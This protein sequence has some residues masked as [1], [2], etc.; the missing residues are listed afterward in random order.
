[1][2]G[3]MKHSNVTSTIIVII[4]VKKRETFRKEAVKGG[5][6]VLIAMTGAVI[7][8]NVYLYYV[9]ILGGAKMLGEFVTVS[10]CVC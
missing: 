4:N 1:M 5:F 2:H 7:A 6:I 3:A 10:C 9:D 8:E